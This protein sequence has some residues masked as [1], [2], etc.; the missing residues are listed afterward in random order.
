MPLTIGILA[1]CPYLNSINSNRAAAAVPVNPQTHIRVVEIE[2]E[3][4]CVLDR[5][6]RERILSS[7]GASATFLPIIESEITGAEIP[8]VARRYRHIV[9]HSVEGERLS[10]FA[11]GK[12]RAIHSS[13]VIVLT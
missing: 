2:L 13:V 11:T 7:F 10:D 1:A 4:N 12:R 5:V 6:E 3:I 8:V 9:V